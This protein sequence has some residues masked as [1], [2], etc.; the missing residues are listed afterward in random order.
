[1]C[2]ANYLK[3]KYIFIWGIIEDTDGYAY[4][5]NSMDF[6]EWAFIHREVV[7]ADAVLKLYSI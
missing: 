5:R 3:F 7:A 2:L 4:S 6:L 1:M